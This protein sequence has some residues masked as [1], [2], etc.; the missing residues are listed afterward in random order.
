[1]T[2]DSRHQPQMEHF[3]GVKHR[4]EEY[5]PLGF[6]I[7]RNMQ[8]RHFWYRGRHRF[9]LYSVHRHIDALGSSRVIDLGGGCG[10]WVSYLSANKRFATSE[11]ALA[12]SSAEALRMASEVLPA[13]TSTFEVDLLALPWS[14][15]WDVAFLL[16]VLE[17]IPDHEEALR[18]VLKTLRP[19][20]LVFITV[21]ALNMLWSWNDE[22]VHHVRRYEKRGFCSLAARCGFH[23]VEARYFMFFLS[24]LLLASRI[25]VRPDLET[26]SKEKTHE[27]LAKMHRIPTPVINEALSWVFSAETPM[28]HYL[29]FPWGTSL[30]TV[31]QKPGE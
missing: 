25:L 28:G 14:N 31:L 22:V 16:D 24:P 6:T 10:G 20:G 17:H 7:L 12:D 30:L 11:M 26:M 27:L 19:G 4:D 15:R 18:Q 29:P 2:T 13:G 3:A 21:P 1:M 9:L 5:D 8:E 23:V